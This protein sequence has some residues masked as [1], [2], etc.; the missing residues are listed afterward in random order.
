MV[1]PAQ[2]DDEMSTGEANVTI[3][4]GLLGCGDIASVHTRGYLA[5]PEEARVTAVSDVIE[6]SAQSLA[7]RV[8]GD[9][10][11]GTSAR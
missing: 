8:G 9:A 4:I 1:A 10:Y 6:T 11:L 5:I 3:K 7:R 2:Q